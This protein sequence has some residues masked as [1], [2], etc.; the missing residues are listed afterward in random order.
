MDKSKAL[1]AFGALAQ[2]TRL[3]AFRR[4]LAKYPDAVSAGDLARHCR[5]P[6]NTMSSHLATLS[7]AGLI[8]ASRDGRSMN[9]RASLDG[10]R[11]LITF[12]TRDCC[13]GRAEIC[14][15]V[16]AGLASFCGPSE[17]ESRHG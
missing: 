14:A 2:E 16:L 12:L 6:H 5:V 10:F 3:S 13:S 11:A 8:A 1:A 15:P 9:Y 7:R 4:L 17:L